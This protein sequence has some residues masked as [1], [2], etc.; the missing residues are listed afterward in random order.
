MGTSETTVKRWFSIERLEIQQLNRIIDYL[1]ITLVELAQ[2]A[3]TPALRQLTLA[4][5][6][7][8]ADNPPLLLVGGSPALDTDRTA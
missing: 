3:E 2:D 8:L 4:Q 7:T 5:E 6:K 1:G